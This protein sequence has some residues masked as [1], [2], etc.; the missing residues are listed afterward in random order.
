M[1]EYYTIQ[2]L[3]I[4]E[5]SRNINNGEV[6]FI[7]TGL[8]MLASYLAKLTHAPDIVLIFE[9]G[10]IGAT[11]SKV[12][13][14]GVADLRLSQCIKASDLFYALGL[15]QGGFIDLGF[16]G[17]AEI[18]CYGNI[19]STV[20]GNYYK[21]TVRLPGSG[22][23]NDIGSLANRTMVIVPHQ[24]RKF[25]SK[26]HYLT[27]PGYLEGGDSRARAGLTKGGPD[28][29][30][31]DLCVFGFCKNSKKM[32]LESIHPGVK[33]SDIEKSTGFEFIISD[34]VRI[35]EKPTH[36]QVKLIRKLD[37]QNIY[38]KK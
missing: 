14:S 7:G 24:K 30:I 10:I 21:P 9:S 33:K 13:A 36:E 6:C 23:A 22:G 28:K 5:A 29:V 37:R 25:P 4:T 20:I 17:A 12:I 2:E 35:T 8:P 16:L 11:P 34:N 3:M 38:L 18:D 31:T 19:N 1:S 27:T 15:L 32:K 26:L